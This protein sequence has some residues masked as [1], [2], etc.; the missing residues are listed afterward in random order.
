[1]GPFDAVASRYGLAC[2]NAD[3][4]ALTKPDVL[5]GMDQIPV[6]TAYQQGGCEIR[7]FD[8]SA[9]AMSTGIT[10]LRILSPFYFVVSAKLV[11]DGIL[12][13]GGLMNRFMAATFTDLIIRVV[14]AF[15][16]SRTS[17]GATAIWFA[18]PVGWT[19]ACVLSILFY[20]TG[21]WNHKDQQEASAA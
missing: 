13:G 10:I 21:P 7:D 2:Q 12:R 1:M 6:I 19:I 17:L 20:R 9:T 8:P 4:I 18:W 14:L 5:S 11:A 16:F 3:R 15:A